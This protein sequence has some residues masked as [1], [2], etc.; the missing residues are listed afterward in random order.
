MTH[1]RPS[2][3][4]RDYAATFA[5]GGVTAAAALWDP[6]IEWHPLGSSIVIRGHDAMCRYYAEWVETIDDLRG[7]VEETVYEDG[8]RVV[9]LI[10][11]SG[12]GRVSGAPA[13]GIYYIV[14]IGL[15]LIFGLAGQLSL[16]QAAF[17]GIGAYASAILTTKLGVPVLVGFAAAIVLSGLVGYVLAAPILRL[18]DV[19]LAMATLA[20]S[21]S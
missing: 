19:Y 15:S 4:L 10:R 3:V 13:A 17:Y 2:E 6:D 11:N 20:S 7:Y 5:D 18:R 8:D 21:M 12:R 16:A 1:Q 9:G 14:C